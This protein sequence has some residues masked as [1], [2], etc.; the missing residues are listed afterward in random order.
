MLPQQG[1]L[2]QVA[3]PVEALASEQGALRAK[4]EQR[5]EVRELAA[6]GQVR[7][8]QPRRSR[9]TVAQQVAPRRSR[10]TVA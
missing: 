7:S 5:A 4:E 1:H 10:A 8:A 3:E 2:V 6:V 9:A